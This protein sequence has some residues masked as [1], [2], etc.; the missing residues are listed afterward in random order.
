MPVVTTALIVLNVV[1]FVFVAVPLALEPAS[2]ADPALEAYVRAI[3]EAAGGRDVSGL[4]SRISAYDL[5]V[6]RWG[7]RPN[8]PSIVTT[9]SSMFLHAGI[10][11]LAGNMLFLW[12]YG[13]NVEHRLGPVRYVGAYVGT[14]A[15]ALLVHWV[16][17]PSSSLPVVGA[18]G[19]ISGILGFY[20]VWFP[21]NR[22]R[23]LWLLPPVPLR[24][25]QVP[26]RIVLGIYL[27][28]DNVVPWLTGGG[29][30]GVAHAAHI[31]GFAAGLGVAWVSG[32][33]PNRRRA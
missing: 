28:F 33:G 19:A 4:I 25:V 12:I 17:N 14:G 21:Y 24:V 20:F 26:A 29:Q 31:G 16:T 15:A 7:F 27:V 1:V 5:L 32:G 10:L 9:A 2:T 11:H 6:F 8:E 13:D 18:S 22:V 3:R 30:A 23:L